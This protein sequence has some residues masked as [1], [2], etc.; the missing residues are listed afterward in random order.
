MEHTLTEEERI[1]RFAALVEWV[2]TDEAR[3]EVR[4]A[5]DRARDDA[6]MFLRMDR[7]ER[8]VHTDPMT[9]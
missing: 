7:V 6:E 4:Q 1:R 9:L 5:T 2:T 8:E 3:E